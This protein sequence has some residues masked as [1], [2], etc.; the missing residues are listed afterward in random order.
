MELSVLQISSKGTL[1][2]LSVEGEVETDPK[3]L[4]CQK[5]NG[6]HGLE[7]EEIAYSRVGPS[8]K[9][10][11]LGSPLSPP[12]I[13]KIRWLLSSACLVSSPF[14]APISQPG[15]QC[16]CVQ[17][18][19]S[20]QLF[21]HGHW[22]WLHMQPTL[23]PVLGLSFGGAPSQHPFLWR[24]LPSWVMEARLCNKQSLDLTLSCLPGDQSEGWQPHRPL[25]D[26]WHVQRLR[27]LRLVC[28][29]VSRPPGG[30]CQQH[31]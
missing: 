4:L 8:H 30:N 15:W 16:P 31:S 10:P 27:Q 1:L 23:K 5:E 13:T 7:R 9:F 25:E 17:L 19:S 3:V 14:S 26:H 6:H 29:P 11:L 28:P 18:P 22:V 21:N 2:Q 12:G 20:L 24:G